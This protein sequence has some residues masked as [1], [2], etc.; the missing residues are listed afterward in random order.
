MAATAKV[1][2]FFKGF[3]YIAQIFVYKDHELEIGYPT[4][5]RHVA[6]IGWDNSSMNAPSWMNEFRTASDFSSSSL[7]NFE[8]S[9]ETSW[10]SQDF[11][12]PR[13]FQSPAISIDYPRPEIP[14]VPKKSKRKRSKNTTPLQS[15][16][17]RSMKSY[18]TAIEDPE[19]V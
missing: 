18:T 7:S 6:H 16:S 13:G 17:S 2:G 19:E 8:Q 10:A 4:D 5:V 12:Q 15:T 14:K 3:K 1:K 9:R 11:D